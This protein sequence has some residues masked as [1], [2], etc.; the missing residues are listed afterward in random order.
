MELLRSFPI[1]LVDD[2]LDDDTAAGRA[3]ARDSSIT[4]VPTTRGDHRR[5][6]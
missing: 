5:P 4:C 1:L 3:H 2:E 6:T